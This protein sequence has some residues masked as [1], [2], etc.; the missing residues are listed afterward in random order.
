MDHLSVR[1]IQCSRYTEVKACLHTDGSSCLCV[2]RIWNFI[3]G[4]LCHPYRHCCTVGTES[5]SVWN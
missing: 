2:R 5:H 1:R 3:W 4:E